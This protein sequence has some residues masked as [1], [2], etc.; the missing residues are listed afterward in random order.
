MDISQSPIRRLARMVSAARLR[1]QVVE[2]LGFK[3]E[4]YR[5][6]GGA[7]NRKT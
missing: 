5:E 2:W 7:N 3:S 1:I 4:E 6:C